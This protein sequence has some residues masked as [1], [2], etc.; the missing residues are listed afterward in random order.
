MFISTGTLDINTDKGNFGLTGVSHS[1]Y[2][3][4]ENRGLGVL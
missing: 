3:N 4:T 2:S 1:K